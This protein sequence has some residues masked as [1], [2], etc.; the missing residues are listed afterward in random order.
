MTGQLVAIKQI[1]RSLQTL[2][3]TKSEYK[4]IASSQNS[5]II[6]GLAL[7]ENIPHVGAD[8]IVMEL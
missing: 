8:T 7:F 1:S 2:E 3:R 5:N 6:R 4:L